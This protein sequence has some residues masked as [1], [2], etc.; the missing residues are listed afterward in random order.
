MREVAA[1]T[2]PMHV[3]LV[4]DG[5]LDRS[6]VKRALRVFDAPLVIH[7][8]LRAG[9]A[10]QA[11]LIRPF[12]CVVLDCQLPGHESLWV[13]EHVRSLGISVPFIVLSGQ[14]DQKTA[15]RLMRAGNTDYVPRGTLSAEHLATTLRH[16]LALRLHPAEKETR[17]VV[18]ALRQ[19]EQRLR[20]ALD[21]AGL[22]IWDYYPRTGTME[23]DAKCKALYGLP[24]DAHVDYRVFVAAVHP[25]DRDRVEAVVRRGLDPTGDGH[26]DCEFRTVAPGQPASWRWLRASG[27]TSFADGKAVRFTGTV[28]DITERKAYAEELARQAEFEQQL[29]GIVSH[30]LRNPIAAMV[31]V[32]GVM[33][34][35][36][37]VS[38]Q[39]AKSL[40]RILS[41]GERATRMIHDLLDF[42]QARRVA[43]MPIQPSATSLH[44][45][46]RQAVDELQ[47]SNP[48]RQILL[49][50]DGDDRGFWD[51][52]RIL[53][54]L[55]NLLSN[56]LTYSPS[57][58]QV[59]LH[60]QDHGDTVQLAVHNGGAPILPAVLP[61]LFQPFKRGTLADDG[62]RSLGL[63]LFIVD[64]VVRAHGGSVEVSST[65]EQG[66]T[67]CVQ[68]P[69]RPSDSPDRAQV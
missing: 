1:A 56:A 35:R 28:L 39:S 13:L 69:R 59:S 19:S 44:I 50:C 36:E 65:E 15:V 41:S 42:T 21:A 26:C 24:A 61:G 18:M 52:D 51:Q 32:A 49:R 27:R 57:D 62:C 66:T 11:L 5:G 68:L 46:A 63:G 14:G 47:A 48:E 30:D 25:D 22:G 55:T 45:L 29:L 37:G 6:T 16:A 8:C 3:L 67:F 9:E 12:D 31:T 38:E 58:A 40:Q 7:E 34:R 53:Q 4:D 54:V 43:G 33:Q 23:W 2:P 17:D 60:V 20:L 64:Q 10:V